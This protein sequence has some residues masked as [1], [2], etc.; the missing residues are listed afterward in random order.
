M[1]EEHP[2]AGGNATTEEYV[3]GQEATRILARNAARLAQIEKDPVARIAGR[4]GAGENP[5]VVTSE[6]IE[7][8]LKELDAASAEVREQLAA[9]PPRIRR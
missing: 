4:V 9:L 3:V 2:P 5:N 1:S 8:A 7:R 6:E